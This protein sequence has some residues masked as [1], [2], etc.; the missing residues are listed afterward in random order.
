MNTNNDVPC[1]P[2][3]GCGEFCWTAGGSGAFVGLDDIVD[4]P[5]SSA[6]YHEGCVT[7]V[8][9]S[10]WLT[11]WQGRTFWQFLST[12]N[13]PCLSVKSTK[14][15]VIYMSYIFVVEVDYTTT[16][17]GISYATNCWWSTIVVAGV[18]YCLRCSLDKGG[19]PAGVG[20]PEQC[21]KIP[22]PIT[23]TLQ[24]DHNDLY[25][26]NSHWMSA[27]MDYCMQSK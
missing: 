18:G 7:R 15:N 14:I 12:W 2:P 10:P 22:F 16:A 5:H 24:F 20:G 3:V 6:D 23:E 21:P 13:P 19:I 4:M 11:S 25:D 17:G 27:L 8:I 1:Q 26:N 9:P